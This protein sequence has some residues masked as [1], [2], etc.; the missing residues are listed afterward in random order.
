MPIIEKKGVTVIITAYNY[1]RYIGDAIRSALMQSH[2]LV[3]VLI[4][5]DGSTDDTPEVVKSFGAAVRYIRQ[6]NSGVSQSRNTGVA[7]AKYEW[8]VF[9]DADDA[10]FPW[11]VETTLRAALRMIEVPAAVM[12]RWIEWDKSTKT[13][14]QPQSDSSSETRLVDVRELVLRNAMAP[15]A[16]VRRS[17]ILELGGYDQWA[18]GAED[19]D[20]W[21]RIASRHRILLIDTYLYKYR[22]H[23]TSLSHN[24]DRQH[25]VT[26]FVLAKAKTNPEIALPWWVWRESCAVQEYQSAMNY[27]MAGRYSR[28]LCHVI[29]SIYNWPMLGTH[30]EPSFPFLARGRFL[31]RHLQFLIFQLIEGRRE[32]VRT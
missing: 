14:I 8:V 2:P 18:G 5:D 11:M 26:R 20:M 28:A 15:T 13:D 31:L 9:L 29:L 16:L 32:N 7:S 4:V 10:L 19:R 30:Y 12:G 23:M 22:L 24:P 3:E 6:A 27:S 25:R 1:G 21:I 17:V